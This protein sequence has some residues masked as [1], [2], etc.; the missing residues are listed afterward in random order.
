MLVRVTK[1]RLEH[2]KWDVSLACEV[3][4]DNSPVMRCI[5]SV[6]HDGHAVR[7][8]LKAERFGNQIRSSPSL[9][10]VIGD[11]SSQERAGDRVGTQISSTQFPNEKLRK[12]RLARPGNS[13]N[14]DKDRLSHQW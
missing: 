9:T 5:D 12:R 6:D 11:M 1:S 3:R 13:C 14:D 4:P 10:R 2:H 8:V 7:Q